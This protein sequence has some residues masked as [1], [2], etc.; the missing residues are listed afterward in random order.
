MRGVLL[1]C[2]LSIP[3]TVNGKFEFDNF[4]EFKFILNFGPTLGLFYIINEFIKVFMV[5]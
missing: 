2:S 3:I 4:F 5:F 1:K